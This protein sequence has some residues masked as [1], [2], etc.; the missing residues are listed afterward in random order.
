MEMKNKNVKMLI[1]GKGN[2]MKNLRSIVRKKG[3]GKKIIFTGFVKAEKIRDYIRSAD[4]GLSPIIPLSIY[5]V[6]SPTKLV[7]YMG[8]GIPVV[9]NN[10]PEQKRIISLSKGG[11]CTP[12]DPKKFADAILKILDDSNLA[13][14]MGEQGREFIKKNRGYDVLA[15][16][17]ENEYIKR[18]GQSRGHGDID[19]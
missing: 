12:Y 1:V 4:V 13:N 17:L 15:T 2:D 9:G 11:I 7:E 10:I 8:E 19:V 3:L 6:S 16:G 14:K 18:C 5:K